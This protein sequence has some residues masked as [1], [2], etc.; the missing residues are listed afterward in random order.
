MPGIPCAREKVRWFSP[1]ANNGIET[2]NEIKVEVVSAD[3]VAGVDTALVEVGSSVGE[4]MHR[5][6]I[7][8]ILNN[9]D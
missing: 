3:N 2:A 5:H 6:P 9:L 4:G 8:I 7:S 1:N